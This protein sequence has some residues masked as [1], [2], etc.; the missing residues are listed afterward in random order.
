MKNYFMKILLAL[1]LVPF[2]VSP[3]FAQQNS[4]V[5]PTDQGTLDVDF[6]TV[7]AKISAGDIVKFNIDFINPNTQKVQEHIDYRLTVFKDG[8]TMFGPIPLTHTSTGS[9]SIPVELGTDGNYDAEIEVEGILF[10]PIPLE[11]V[12]FNIQV[13]DAAAQ[14]PTPSPNG[15]GGGCLIATATYGSEL[16]PQV[17]QLR[18]IRDNVVL[19]TESGLAFMTTFN[20]LYYSFS[21][22]VADFERENPVFREVMKLGLTPLLSTLSVFNHVEIN[23]EEDMLAYGISIITL[24]LGIYIGIPAFAILKLYQFRRN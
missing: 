12:S 20:Q 7:P 23:S 8:V 16:A 9:V 3:A 24:N 22:S 5:L 19:N 6:S 4:V 1:L 11:K 13:G 14:T 10:Q 18:E 15:E 17:Q 21:P 2:L